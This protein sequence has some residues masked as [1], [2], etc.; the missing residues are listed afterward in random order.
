MVWSQISNLIPN[1]S[2]NHNLNVRFVNGKCEP[3]FNIYI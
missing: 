1:Y 3:I 2:F